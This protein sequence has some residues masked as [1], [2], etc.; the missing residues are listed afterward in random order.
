ML[1]AP[2]DLLQRSTLALGVVQFNTVGTLHIHVAYL[3][4]TQACPEKA[5]LM[6]KG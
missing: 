6:P 1:V 3:C 4:R 5:T 2:I